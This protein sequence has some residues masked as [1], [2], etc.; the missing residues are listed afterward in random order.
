MRELSSVGGGGGGSTGVRLL[1]FFSLF[2]LFWPLSLT[3][4]GLVALRWTTML[5]LVAAF[6]V[7]TAAAEEVSWLAR[8]AILTAAASECVDWWRPFSGCEQM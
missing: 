8:V 3:L 2:S 4:V 5:L 7:L 6:L 1:S